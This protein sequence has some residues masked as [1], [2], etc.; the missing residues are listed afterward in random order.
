MRRVALATCAGTDVDPD[1]PIL[2]DAL[3][4][5][6][7][8]GA[9]CVWDDAS[10][11]WDAY[12]LVVVRS[13]WD[14]AGQRARFLRWA[15][16]LARVV[17]PYDVLE[18]SSDKRY[19]VDLAARGVPVVAS[20]F[21]DVGAE[22]V[23]PGGDFV[24]KPCVGAG[25]MDAERYR[26]DEHAAA[27]SHVARL[28]GAGRDVLIQPYIDSVDDIGE[29]ALIFIDGAFSHAMTKAAMLNVTALD[30]N[31]LFRREQLSRATPEPEALALAHAAL[32][33]RFEDLL[34]ARV[35]LV[36]TPTGW[37][38]MELELVEPSLFLAFDDE[39]AHRL[40]AGI[41]ARLR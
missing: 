27:R 6:G 12:D 31:A 35:D 18:Y 40:A 16:S 36:A 32:A 26:G 34:Y 41:V 30:R 22:P 25:S 13:T 14:Y 10:I 20:E 29:H 38:L 11:D 28:H 39:A 23:F 2:L 21:F 15:R 1:A 19:L 33:R 17:N 8:A 9:L 7:V 5:A 3:A 24:V 37:A 4:R